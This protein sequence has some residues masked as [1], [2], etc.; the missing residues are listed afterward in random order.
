MNINLRVK[1]AMA[2]RVRDLLL[3]NPFGDAPADQVSAQFVEKV[4]R[5][6]AMLTQ[7]EAG[8]M[9]SRTSTRH[10]R[11]LRREML[12]LPVRHLLKIAKSVAA[13]HP[14]VASG[15]RRPAFGRSE[16][17]F[18]ASV[19]AIAREA[20][21]HRALFLEHGMSEESLEELSQM[22]QAYEAAV[23]DSNAGRRAHTGAR[24]EL[25]AVTRDLMRLLQQLDGIVLYRFR[26]RPDLMGAWESARNI[27]WPLTEPAKPVAPVQMVK[28][29]A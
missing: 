14:E 26:D 29:A 6:Q 12:R 1:V 21:S 11:L 28:P 13:E 23:H 27:A 3:A 20:E 25:K 15:L 24:A 18:Q 19:R 5:A 17:V 7:Q 8:E 4:G 2:V 9:A 16:E 10:R 22:L